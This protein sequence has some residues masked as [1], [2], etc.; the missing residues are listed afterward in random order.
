MTINGVR[1]TSFSTVLSSVIAALLLLEVTT[2]T[3]VSA[4]GGVELPRSAGTVAADVLVQGAVDIEVQPLIAALESSQEIQLAAWTFWQG[5]IGGKSVVV[6]RTEVGPINATAAT[7]LGI[8]TFRPQLVINQG[9]AGAQVPQ[10]KVFD[11]VVGQATTD[12]SAFVSAPAR[13]GKGSTMSRWRP[14]YHSLRIDGR[15]REF[16]GGFPGD[17][18]ALGVALS[19]QYP[20]GRVIKGVIGSAYQ[21]NNEIDRLNWLHKTYGTVSEDMESVFAAGAALA[22]N[23]RFLAI[24]VIS[25]SDF[26]DP[27]GKPAAAQHGADFVVSVIKGLP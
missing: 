27:Q 6:S 2:A 7:T 12:Y 17:E 23:T 14:I 25:D 19:T 21:F 22:L 16:K 13:S 5:K 1:Y 8:L 26:S 24:R 10:L 3:S 15:P 11:I 20:Q 18:V 4:S 9:T